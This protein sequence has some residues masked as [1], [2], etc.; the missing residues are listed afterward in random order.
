LNLLFFKLG[1]NTI[2][3]IGNAIEVPRPSKLRCSW[4]VSRIQGVRGADFEKGFKPLLAINQKM[5][6]CKFQTQESFVM[7]VI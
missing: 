4:A 5:S 6:I 1:L 2:G 7:G 3:D